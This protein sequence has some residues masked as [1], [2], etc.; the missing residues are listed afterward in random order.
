MRPTTLA[1]VALGPRRI[2]P[3]LDHKSRVAVWTSTLHSKVTRSLSECK[4]FSL[5]SIYSSPNVSK[6]EQNP[7]FVLC[8]SGPSSGIEIQAQC[9]RRSQAMRHANISTSQR[10][11]RNLPVGAG[12]AVMVKISAVTIPAQVGSIAHPDC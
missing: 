6:S 3:R 4:K 11:V 12:E 7:I 2:T 9:I 5:Q 8:I 1:L 10:Y